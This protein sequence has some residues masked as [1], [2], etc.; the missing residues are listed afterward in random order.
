MNIRNIAAATSTEGVSQE[1]DSGWMGAGMN[2][3]PSWKLFP[4][5]DAPDLPKPQP[6]VHK[7]PIERKTFFKF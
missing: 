4:V 2:Q 1:R 7:E 6:L 3:G 5:M